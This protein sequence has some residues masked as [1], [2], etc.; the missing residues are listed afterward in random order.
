MTVTSFSSRAPK[1]RERARAEP[2]RNAFAYT[3]EDAQKMGA[4]GKSKIYELKAS[5][6]LRLINVDGRTMVD[7]DS[8]RALLKVDQESVPQVAGQK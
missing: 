5:G 7:G 3:I 6:R 8:L 4:P 1:K 2:S